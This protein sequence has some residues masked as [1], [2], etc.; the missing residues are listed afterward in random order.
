M[1]LKIQNKYV[2]LVKLFTGETEILGE[3]EE[4]LS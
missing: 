1:H 3:S 4:N 2:A